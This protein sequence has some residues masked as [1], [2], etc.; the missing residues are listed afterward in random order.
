M[1]SPGE[2]VDVGAAAALAARPGYTS[3]L[4][5]VRARLEAGGDPETV[6]LRG[7][8]D[9]TRA[10]LADLLGRR[11]L[12]GETVRVRLADLDAAL[13]AS[14]VGAGLVE[15]LEATGG[16]LADRRA[17]RAQAEQAWAAVWE[18]DHAALG[19]PEVA[20]WVEGLR[21]SGVLRRLTADPDDARRLLTHALEV[22]ARLPSRGV[23]RSVLA[24]DATGD[25]HALDHG[26][27]LATVVLRAAATLAA[28][29][30]PSSARDRRQLWADV[31]VACDPLSASVL[32]L[33]L[34]LAGDDI[35]ADA[36]N[37][38]A[39]AGCPLRLTLH[40]L[41]STERD[42]EGLRTPHRRVLVCENPAVVAAATY[43][44]DACEPAAPLVCI[45]GMPDV[46]CDRLLSALASAGVEVAFH[47]DFDWGGLRIGNLLVA[48]YGA[49]PWRFS[50]A[51][52]RAALER[53]A[54]AQPLGGEP[55][56]AAWDIE[57]TAAI[58]RADR[59]VAEEQLVDQLVGD[60]LPE[61]L[62]G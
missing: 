40:Q 20:A 56:D 27:P 55:V 8:D 36:A 59:G 18:V 49:V 62:G 25:P 57:L 4:A 45:D 22:V 15:V 10:A 31:G 14:R 19:R 41:D 21:S 46:A 61:E 51:D 29:E 28:R 52:Y 3:L 60:L 47:A 7:L 58:R 12:P 43:R 37:H 6:T 35:V 34:R 16:P 23:A 9:D 13:R 1:S 33:G 39:V 44:L 5:A 17:A 26:R 54:C 11:R 50:T 38:H 2:T 42:N 53:A 48:R 24:A 32:V 30:V